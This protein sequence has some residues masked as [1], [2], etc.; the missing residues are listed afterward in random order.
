[1]E[2]KKFYC[3]NCN[4]E[5]SEKENICPNC[6]LEFTEE[7]SEE[8]INTLKPDK[9]FSEIIYDYALY[10]TK[11]NIKFILMFAKILKII[12][13]SLAV[14]FIIMGFCINYVALFISGISCVLTAFLAIPFL[15]WKAYILKNLYDI[16]LEL[17]SN[18]R[19]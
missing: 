19:D 13:F 7:S 10:D 5:V 8:K 3:E 11:K 4:E 12:L 16:N 6:G 15:E 1:M 2:E 18:K 14:L 17:K 9:E